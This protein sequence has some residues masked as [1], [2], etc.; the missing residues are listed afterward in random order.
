MKSRARLRGRGGWRL[1]CSR[2]RAE[3]GIF[4]LTRSECLFDLRQG[5]ADEGEGE[6]ASDGSAHGDRQGARR[7]GDGGGR[8]VCGGG[9][10]TDGGDGGDVGK[11]SICRGARVADEYGWRMRSWDPP[12]P[13]AALTGDDAD[14]DA[15]GVDE[16]CLVPVAPVASAAAARALLRGASC[17]AGMHPD[18][19]AEVHD[20]SRGTRVALGCRES[21]SLRGTHV[22]R[23]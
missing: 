5:I 9:G 12:A 4:P 1:V 20:S 16:D 11:L 3:S 2:G 17:L 13:A 10:A 23:V 15:D 21:H 8:D 18:A 22:R 14:A 19:A 6:G 7:D